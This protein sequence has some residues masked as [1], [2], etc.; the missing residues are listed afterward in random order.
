MNKKNMV[1]IVWVLLPV[2]S[3][4]G[5]RV[6][7]A[8]G[9]V[10]GVIV[11]TDVSSVTIPVGST[12]SYK[13]SVTTGSP[14][15]DKEWQVI[16]SATYLWSASL[17]TPSPTDTSE[18]TVTTSPLLLN[19]NNYTST[20]SCTV[21]YQVQK[22]DPGQADDGQVA[23]IAGTDSK[24][25]VINVVAIGSL[26][27]NDP[28]NG[29]TNVPETL[30][31][32]QGTTVSFR[33]LAIPSSD[34]FPSGLP[35]WGGASGASGTGATT[36]VTFSTLSTG[37]SDSKAVV[38]TC[39]TS[40]ATADVVVFDLVPHANSTDTS[41][42]NHNYSHIG[43]G[44]ILD[45]TY[46]TIPSGISADQIGHVQWSLDRGGV[47]MPNTTTQFYAGQTGG[48][49]NITLQIVT[50]PSVNA[51][52]SLTK[53]IVAPNLA[54]QVIQYN[55]T[56]HNN[57]TASAG[58][59]GYYCLKPSDV[60]FKQVGVR[61]IDCQPTIASGFLSTIKG[62]HMGKRNATGEPILT[63]SPWYGLRFDPISYIN[64]WRLNGIDQ[65]GFQ[66]PPD[67]T[68]YAPSGYG[69]GKVTY[70]IPVVSLFKLL[71]AVCCTRVET[72]ADS[73]RASGPSS[74]TRASCGQSG[75]VADA[76]CC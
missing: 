37:T 30:Y 34:A 42:P 36:T 38:A 65:S 9:S 5:A 67:M 23:T 55:K 58:F 43:V 2:L 26:Q 63:I 12:A 6:A 7:H 46:T 70:Q 50:G 22:S 57:G 18:T 21:S 60:S 68:N 35:T 73:S 24:P 61:E 39:G 13:A 64:T 49:V 75:L 56:Y 32:L 3:A 52:R 47:M 11:T 14:Q 72:A 71:G 62:Y 25:V 31:V 69:I 74:R 19:S 66:K 59:L 15:P 51:S 20:V 16:G 4:F 44:E 28:I 29:W 33:A 76:A 45:L 17:G 8:Q 40:T 54:Y 53:L 41:V 48:G 10:S 27:Y 1:C